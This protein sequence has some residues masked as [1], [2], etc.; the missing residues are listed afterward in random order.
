MN[1]ISNVYLYIKVNYY[2]FND[3]NQILFE[4][5]IKDRFYLVK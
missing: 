2:I 3:N 1:I 4:I 5:I